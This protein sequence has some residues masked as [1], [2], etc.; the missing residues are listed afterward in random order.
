MRFAVLGFIAAFPF[1][2]LA[3]KKGNAVVVSDA[4]EPTADVDA[5]SSVAASASSSAPLPRV[6]SLFDAEN[7]L[8]KDT[9][10]APRSWTGN[11]K[12]KARLT[13]TQGDATVI[14]HMSIAADDK[15]SIVCTITGD[16]CTGT[17]TEAKQPKTGKAPPPR[18]H[19]LTLRRDAYGAIHYRVEN[20]SASVCPK[21]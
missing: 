1:A 19:K 11:Y 5:A 9:P 21:L 3:C 10:A 6:V 7:G 17:E 8:L 12:C 2:A 18:T 15:A 20:G 14:G 4:G 16:T 13:L